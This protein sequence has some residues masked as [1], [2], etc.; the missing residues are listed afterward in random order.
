MAEKEEKKQQSNPQD[1]S[2]EKDSK[3]TANNR[4]LP[5]I[6]IVAVMV[7]CAGMGFGL[8][9]ILGGQSTNGESGSEAQ[10]VD[11]SK[12]LAAD[13]DSA[14]ETNDYW[15]YDF[16]PVIANLN[17]PRVS[18]FVSISITLQIS[19]AINEKKCTALI[20][21]KKPILT[22]WL[23]VYLM[24]LSVE[25]IRGDENV[26]KVQVHILDAFNDKLF[27]ESQLRIESVLF[28]NIAVQ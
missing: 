21:E 9:K 8:G 7:F 24:S 12:E 4:F 16:E 3:K 23:T 6:I 13:I 11:L 1:S 27:P 17:E 25:E 2:S 20:E 26:K 15:Y 19:K 14:D 10:E 28:R 5:W 18:R 22:N